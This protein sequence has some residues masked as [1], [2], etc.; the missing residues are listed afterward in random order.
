MPSRLIIIY[1]YC[2]LLS[3]SCP[4][5]Q[6]LYYRKKFVLRRN[7]QSQG[8]RLDHTAV[9]CSRACAST[10]HSIVSNSRLYTHSRCKD[11]SIHVYIY[12]CVCVY[13]K[14]SDR[15]VSRGVIRHTQTHSLRHSVLAAKGDVTEKNGASRGGG[16]NA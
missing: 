3:Q 12:M 2:L 7:R 11:L 9:T 1:G 8:T 10:V 5:F 6:K 16:Q 4:P 13:V 15:L 14:I